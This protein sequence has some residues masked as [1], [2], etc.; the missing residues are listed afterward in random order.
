MTGEE[1]KSWKAEKSDFTD[2]FADSGEIDHWSNTGNSKDCGKDI[3]KD[4]S[5]KDVQVFVYT[6]Q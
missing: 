1:D 5:N 3:T 2:C 6:M 4:Q